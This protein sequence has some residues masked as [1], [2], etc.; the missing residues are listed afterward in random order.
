MSDKKRV[1]VQFFTDKELK[2]VLCSDGAVFSFQTEFVNT[3][4]A[5]GAML[6]HEAV[7]YKRRPEYENIP[8]D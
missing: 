2:L 4:D 8:Q 7:S 3:R 5:G 1:P 6:S